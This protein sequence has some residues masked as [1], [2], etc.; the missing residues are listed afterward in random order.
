MKIARRNFLTGTMALT[1]TGMPVAGSTWTASHALAAPRISKKSGFHSPEAWAREY[2]L[3][4]GPLG[5]QS[6]SQIEQVVGATGGVYDDRGGVLA[7]IVHYWLRAWS[8]MAELTGQE[9]YLETAISFVDYMFDHTDEKRIARGDIAE[10]YIRDPGGFQGTGTGGPFWKRGGEANALNTGQVSHGIMRFV[11]TLM[12]NKERWPVYQDLAQRYFE[13]VKRAVDAFEPDW[14]TFGDAGSYYYRDSEG[15]NVLGTTETA[16][17][18]TATMC[19]AHIYLDKWQPDPARRD[20]VRRHL[21][22]WLDHFITEQ[23]D[24]TLT[25]PYIIHDKLQRTE[26]TGHATVDVDFLVL[27]YRNGF[28][29]LKPKH[30]DA[31]AK[32]FATRIWNE[33]GS[34]N[35]YID[36]TTDPDYT[37]QFNAGFG[38]IELADQDPK[39]AEMALKTFERFYPHTSEPGIL[40]ARPLLGWA[41]LLSRFG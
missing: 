38:W 37:E 40:W 11:D 33:D 6:R 17:N 5:P 1:V 39:I 30:M 18:Q 3:R 8:R 4:W 35:T 34:L 36:G 14:K 2:E 24:G 27:A 16:F 29:E 21:R 26:D 41:N 22:Y 19:A 28:D 12:E 23:P 31:L 9:K 13:G 7:W 10:A 15:S 32:T 25:W 20:K